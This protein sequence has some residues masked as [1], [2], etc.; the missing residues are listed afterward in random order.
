MRQTVIGH[1]FLLGTLH[2][3]NSSYQ[4]KAVCY[5]KCQD[6]EYS[7]VVHARGY[8]GHSLYHITCF[9]DYIQL[10]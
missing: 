4:M 3:E 6:A 10:K 9:C 5:L 8:V 1:G 2:N 7:L